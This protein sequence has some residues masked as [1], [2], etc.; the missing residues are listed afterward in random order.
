VRALTLLSLQRNQIASVDGPSLGALSTLR[1]L[2]LAANLL[3]DLPPSF[4]QLRS[5]SHLDLCN[6]QLAAVPAALELLS[7]LT[8]INLSNNK[9]LT[10]SKTPLPS[11]LLRMP[12]VV[13]EGKVS[14]LCGCCSFASAM[15]RT[16]SASTR[17]PEWQ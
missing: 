6:N 12:G 14:A 8:A 17:S 7:A 11:W 5:L 4:S 15:P 2:L 3:S 9:P 10:Q 1:T 16:V 13:V